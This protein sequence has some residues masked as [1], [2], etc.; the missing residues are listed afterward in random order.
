MVMTN[1]TVFSSLLLLLAQVCCI[2]PSSVPT[3]R[4]VSGKPE[5]FVQTNYTK[6]VPRTALAGEAMVTHEEYLAR[7]QFPN[8]FILN[9]QIVIKTEKHAFAIPHGHVLT[10]LDT[11]EINGENLAIYLDAHDD[12]GSGEMYYVKP[13]M[14]LANFMYVRSHTGDEKGLE[15]IQFVSPKSFKFKGKFEVDPASKTMVKAYDLLFLGQDAQGIHATYR[16]R[17]LADPARVAL[18]RDLTIPADADPFRYG[19]LAL[20]I[21]RCSGRALDYTVI[22]D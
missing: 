11:I 20:R 13:D 15:K 2:G 12:N 21:H 6:G 22:A 8:H 16:E 7:R 17:D 9:R 4:L 5:P 1:K 19:N 3:A 10:F 18:T 14:E